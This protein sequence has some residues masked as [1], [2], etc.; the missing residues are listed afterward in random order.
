MTPNLKKLAR[1]QTGAALV[2]AMV[3]LFILTILG[4]SA[5]RTSTLEQLMTGNIQEMVR[6]LQVADSGASKVLVDLNTFNTIP[7]SGNYEDFSYN[8]TG[9]NDQMQASAR[10]YKPIHIQ[11]TGNRSQCGK[12]KPSG[13]GTGYAYWDQVVTGRTLV[14]AAVP[15][16]QITLQQGA[17]KESPK[18][19]G[20]FVNK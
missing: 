15:R 17:C 20:E 10:I 1:K 6:G 8:V 3:I 2:M 14:S 16:A 4:V 13:T 19:Q 5:L 18:D 12:R 9:T 11:I 7:S